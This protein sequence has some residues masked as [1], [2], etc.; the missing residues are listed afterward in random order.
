MGVKNMVR[1][2]DTPGNYLAKLFRL[3]ATLVNR[4]DQLG[5]QGSAHIQILH[6]DWCA[7][8]HGRACNCV[9]IIRRMPAPPKPRGQA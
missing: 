8:F 9:P 6:D 7:F 1:Q 4:D 5:M 2:Q 3:G